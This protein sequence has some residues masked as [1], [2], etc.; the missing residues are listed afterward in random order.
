VKVAA[1]LLFASLVLFGQLQ[2]REGNF[3]IR[4]E[5]TAVLQTGAPIPFQITV[6]D[7][8][9]QPVADAKVT[10]QIE[11]AEH[12]KTK[13]FRAS[14]MDRGA[15]VAKPVFPDPG[16]WDVYVEVNRNGAISSRTIQF[17]V[18]Q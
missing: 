18:P 3:D 6:R 13:L 4:F 10:L 17:N 12:A 1:L 5:P 8:R 2:Q 9:K 15:Y 7:D 14:A 11:T 16:T